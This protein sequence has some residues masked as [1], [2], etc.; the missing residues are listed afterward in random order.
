MYSYAL[1]CIKTAYP[2]VKYTRNYSPSR[3]QFQIFLKNKDGSESELYNKNIKDGAFSERT[4][5]IAI[6]RI[7]AK[8][9]NE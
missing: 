9:E 6:E 1:D 5:L 8:V 3:G 7:K 2:N 4:A